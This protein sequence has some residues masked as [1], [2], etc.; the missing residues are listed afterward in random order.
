M[1]SYFILKNLFFVKLLFFLI[2]FEK[3]LGLYTGVMGATLSGT[4]NPTQTICNPSGIV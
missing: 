2:D 3:G 4:R 1:L